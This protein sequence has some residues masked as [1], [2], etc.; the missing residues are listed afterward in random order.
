[1]QESLVLLS[2]NA[3]PA[4][5]KKIS[6]KIQVPLGEMEVFKFADDESFCKINV[7]IRKRDVF[8]IQ[9]TCRPVNDNLMELLIIIDACKR[10]SARSITAV[11][12]Y[13]GYSRTDKKDQ[14]RVPITAKL[15]ADLLTTAGA[16]RLIS[17][18]LHAESI[19]GFFNIP[20]DHLYALPIFIRYIREE[21]GTKDLVIVSPDAGGVA[22]ARAHAKRLGAEL[23][24]VDKR[25]VGNQDQ[26]EVYNVIGEVKGKRCVLIDDIIDTAGSIT[27]AGEVLKERGAKEVRAM[28]TH[29]VL[30]P[31]AIE[32]I[33]QSPLEEV[34]VTDTIPIPPEKYSKKLTVLTVSE[35]LAETIKRIFY[36]ESVS[37]LFV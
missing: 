36:G 3:H 20:V 19:Q 7:N 33:E 29:P 2:G 31:P 32:R 10:A 26:T 28:V 27:K 15:V 21:L 5:A 18:D 25:R 8:V 24:I 12:P 37:S 17:I 23:A 22:R 9:P 30:S 35:L 11:V 34:V 13:Y 1:M 14:P 4:L 6:E 16:N